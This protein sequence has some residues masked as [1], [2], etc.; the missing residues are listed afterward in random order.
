MDEFLKT[1]IFFYMIGIR[2]TSLLSQN[3]NIKYVVEE[4]KLF[5]GFK[6]LNKYAANSQSNSLLP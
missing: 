6:Y 4:H 1:A 3:P 2:N 5:M